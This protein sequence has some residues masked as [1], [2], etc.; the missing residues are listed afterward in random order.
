M[1]THWYTVEYDE[2]GVAWLVSD[3]THDAHCCLE[4][5][6]RVDVGGMQPPQ[7]PV[8]EPTPVG[9]RAR[10]WWTTELRITVWL[11]GIFC[12]LSV[13]SGWWDIGLICGSL[14]LGVVL[15]VSRRWRWG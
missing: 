13:L 5:G 11:L 14:A 3:D 8:Q 1:P 4:H 12:A 7:Y 15:E 6:M 10:R 9:E 2:N